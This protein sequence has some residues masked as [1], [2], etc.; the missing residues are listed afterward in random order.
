MPS[1][2]ENRFLLSYDW[3]LAA[4]RDYDA[5]IVPASNFATT[6]TVPVGHRPGIG[7]FGTYDMAGNVRE[8]CWNEGDARQRYIL[9]GAWNEP[10]YM[11]TS[12][13]AQPPMDRSETNG[14][15]CVLYVSPPSEQLLAPLIPDY[16][17]YS[18]EKPVSDQEFEAI[19]RAYAY[20]AK[21]LN[22]KVTVAKETEAYRHEIATFDASYG[23]ETVTAHLFLP[24]RGKPPFQTV[25]Y[26]GGADGARATEFYDN[27]YYRCNA[28]FLVETGRAVVWPIYKGTFERGGGQSLAS[29]NDRKQRAIQRSHDFRATIDY[30]HERDDIDR[31]KLAYFGASMGAATGPVLLA[32]ED[33]IKTG[34]LLVGGLNKN[35]SKPLPDLDTFNFAPRVK[36]P[37]LMINGRTDDIFPYEISQLPLFNALGTEEKDKSHRVFLGGHSVP[38]EHVVNETLAWLDRY[39]GSPSSGDAAEGKIDPI[40]AAKREEDTGNLFL[41]WKKYVEA[42]KRFKKALELGQPVWGTE[43]QETLKLTFRLATAIEKQDRND[44]A[45]GLFERTL[46]SQRK[47]LG[48]DHEDVRETTRALCGL[49]KRNVWT[50]CSAA[51]RPREDYNRAAELARRTIETAPSEGSWCYLSYAHYRCD[52]TQAS[53]AAMEESL[54]TPNEEWIGQW[55]LAAMVHHRA[56]NQEL[57]RDWYSAACEWVR[58]TDNRWSSTRQLRKEAG[59]LLNLPTDWPP[60]DWTREQYLEAYN[61]M[62][63]K[64]PNLYRLYHCRASHHGRLRQWEEAAA[65]Y[66]K[67]SELEPANWHSWQAH[68]AAE[69]YSKPTEDHTAMFRRLYDAF[70]DYK[71]ANPRMGLVLHCSLA[72]NADLDREELNRIADGVLAEL[73]TRP[74]LEL[75]KGMALYRLGR[76]EEALKVLPGSEREYTNPKDELLALL[77]RAMTHHQLGDAYTC[78]KILDQARQGIQDKAA[79]PDGPM[80]RYEDRPVV[81]CMI[82][83]ALREAEA[84]IEGTNASAEQVT[85]AMAN[86]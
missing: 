73:P 58:K 1:V 67:A 43:H 51:G 52:D 8:W 25:V 32:L 23:K 84:L 41:S 65:D 22:A 38:Q 54:A 18:K 34:I 49:W 72:P 26:F 81:W 7:P 31:E 29:L 63:E 78:R 70:H 75:G 46:A 57:A 12:S 24:R 2:S 15:R 5:H 20:E 80:L 30:L 14:F 16:R 60:A 6:G 64:Y 45:I 27:A 76:F 21:P 79:T 10:E 11:F 13:V 37:I 40:A 56:G 85:A 36:I 4:G 39:L 50:I 35:R 71:N 44:E 53:L 77:F 3:Q 55:F 59:S 48:T 28:A 62:I 42:E 68:A 69:L 17:D 19:K 86:E 33:R 83:I 9:G 82:Q 47:L 74:Y 66:Q 61:R